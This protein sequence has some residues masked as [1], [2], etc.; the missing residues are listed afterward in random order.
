M[1]M[2]VCD[3]CFDLSD[4]ACRP[5]NVQ[6]SGTVLNSQDIR[7]PRSVQRSHQVS[8]PARVSEFE[9]RL[10]LTSILLETADILILT[11]TTVS[12]P[13]WSRYSV[14]KSCQT[15][16]RQSSCRAGKSAA[17]DVILA[18]Y[19]L[20]PRPGIR[21]RS[22]VLDLTDA[23][24]CLHIGLWLHRQQSSRTIKTISEKLL[25]ES[26]QIPRVGG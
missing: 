24:D 26:G 22:R 15:G 7:Q 16:S 3:C 19:Y 5:D 1:H 4:S 8:K 21:N 12:S 6:R 11:N 18:F 20:A 14:F 2:C 10:F 9:S 23:L 25:G 13:I 17:T